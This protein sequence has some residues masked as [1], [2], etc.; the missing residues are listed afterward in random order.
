MA[1]TDI[2]KTNRVRELRQSR[3]LTIKQ[4]ADQLGV[5]FSSLQKIETGG[6]DLDLTWIAKLSQALKVKPY[7]LLPKEWQPVGA[8]SGAEKLQ[9]DLQ[10]MIEIVEDFLTKRKLSLSP[11][12]KAELIVVLLDIAAETPA[13]E[14]L[15][16]RLYYTMDTFVRIKSA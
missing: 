14:N 9:K 15:Q 5:A 10:D 3:D 2:A 12:H 11:A 13:N 1:K 8:G 16:N 7:E 6:V 4:L